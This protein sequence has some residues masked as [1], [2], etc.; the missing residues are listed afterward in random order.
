M[1]RSAAPVGRSRESPLRLAT[2]GE[3]PLRARR[4]D[5]HPAPQQLRAMMISEFEQWLRSRANQ[6]KRAFHEDTILAYATWRR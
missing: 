2:A 6:H 3:S 1:S 4:P 5:G